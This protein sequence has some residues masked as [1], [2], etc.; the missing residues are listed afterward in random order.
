[1]DSEEEEEGLFKADAVNEGE[2][3]REKERRTIMLD[4]QSEPAIYLIYFLKLEAPSNKRHY[5]T[6]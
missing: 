6:H 4:G 5:V 1:V 3:E 2:R